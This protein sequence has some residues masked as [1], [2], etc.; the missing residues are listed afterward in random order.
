MMNTIQLKLFITIASFIIFHSC[1]NNQRN[2]DEAIN[3]LKSAAA[4]SLFFEIEAD[5]NLNI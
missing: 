5:S 4:D 3:N 1:T 2:L